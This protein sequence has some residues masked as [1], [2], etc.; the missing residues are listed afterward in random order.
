VPGML[1]ILQHTPLWVFALLAVLVW[2]GLQAIGPR[3]VP[4]WRLVIIPL[5]FVGWGLTSLITPAASPF[6]I[7]DW[8]GTAA[9]GWAMGWAATSLERVIITFDPTKRLIH[10]PGSVLPLVRNVAIFA[11]KYGLTAAVAISP[12][13]RQN[14]YLW[15]IAV[16]GASAGYFLSWLT[17]FAA[18]YR[19]AKSENL[20]AQ[21]T[22][23]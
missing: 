13:Q 20:A 11:I 12:S 8:L 9:I 14:I 17:R 6:S 1:T 5:I 4:V 21:P 10:V 23:S 15:D 22:N 2:F 7:A 3:S 19:R 18:A 16:S